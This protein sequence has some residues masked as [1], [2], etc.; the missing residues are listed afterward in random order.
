[1]KNYIR[2][3][4]FLNNKQKP[5]HIQEMIDEV[6]SFKSMLPTS[7][8]HINLND[9]QNSIDDSVPPPLVKEWAVFGMSEEDI[10]ERAGNQKDKGQRFAGSTLSSNYKPSQFVEHSSK[11]VFPSGINLE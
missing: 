11:L 5:N 1:M 2:D 10:M 4:R 8:K 3:N 9:S 7:V 6:R